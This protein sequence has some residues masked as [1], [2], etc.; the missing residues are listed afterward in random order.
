MKPLIWGD[1]E[2]NYFFAEGWTTQIR[3]KGFEKLGFRRTG[4]LGGE[5]IVRSDVRWKLPDGRIKCGASEPMTSHRPDVRFAPVR[6]LGE[7][8]LR[9]PFRAPPD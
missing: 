9:S 6:R 5:A 4:F 8:G 7:S 1:D 2:A 3:L